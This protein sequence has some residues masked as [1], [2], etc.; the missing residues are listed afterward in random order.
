MLATQ[1]QH[2]MVQVRAQCGRQGPLDQ[3]TPAQGE[4]LL[5]FSKSRRLAGREKDSRCWRFQGGLW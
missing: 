3:K 4:Q 2:D 5:G 1:N